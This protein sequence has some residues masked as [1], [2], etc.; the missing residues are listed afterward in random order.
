MGRSEHFV[1]FYDKDI[2]LTDS[3]A[4]F[5]AEGIRQQ[6]AAIIIATPDHR[7]DI[8]ENLVKQ[9]LNLEEMEATGRL[10]FLGTATL[11]PAAGPR[12]SRPGGLM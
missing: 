6:D 10:L 9:A 3:V 12:R 8:R 2:F 7:R 5:M 11:S 1:Q 4:A